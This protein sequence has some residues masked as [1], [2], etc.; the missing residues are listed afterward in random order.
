MEPKNN[1]D[2]IS[3]FHYVWGGLKLFVS[4]SV[5]IYVAMGIGMIWSGSETGEAELLFSGGVFLIFGIFAFLIVVALGI[6]SLLCGKYIKERRN[7][8]FCLV[9]A[10]LACANAPLGT[11]LGIFTIIEIEKPE[12]KAMFEANK[13]K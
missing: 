9:M 8:M 1:L 3:T 2:L 13:K 4:L 10:G 5:L 11:I 7:R 12:I 6:M